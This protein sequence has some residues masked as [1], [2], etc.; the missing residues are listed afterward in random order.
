MGSHQPRHHRSVWSWVLTEYWYHTIFEF[1][2]HFGPNYTSAKFHVCISNG[3]NALM[4]FYW[5]GGTNTQTDRQTDR[6]V[7]NNKGKK[8]CFIT[9]CKAHSKVTHIKQRK[10]F[11]HLK[12]PGYNIEFFLYPRRFRWWKYFCCSM[13]HFA[14]ALTHCYKTSFLHL[15][16]QFFY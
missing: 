4:T 3:C 12:R 16:L 2:L 8:T 6:H 15:Y 9:M 10:Y 11:H 1:D 7:K 13:C 5:Y 14:M